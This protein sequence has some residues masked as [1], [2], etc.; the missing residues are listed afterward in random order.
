MSKVDL[1]SRQWCELVF[2]GRN[3][4]YGAYRLRSKAGARNLKSLITLFVTFAIIVAVFLAKVAVS[5]LMK[6]NNHEEDQVTAFAELEQKK[7][8]KVSRNENSDMINELWNTRSSVSVLF[9]AL[10]VPISVYEYRN[11]KIELLRSN[12]LYEK[13]IN[14][15]NE[16]LMKQEAAELRKIFKSTVIGNL[17]YE[18]EISR[19]LKRYHILA[20]IL[21]QRENT[22]IIMVTYLEILNK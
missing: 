10:D 17:G 9:E 7:E 4:E 8:E 13:Y 2:E 11:D 20:K 21:G 19:N 15:A 6:E 16:E 1:V 22:W 3:K 5:N 12:E 18:L 14:I